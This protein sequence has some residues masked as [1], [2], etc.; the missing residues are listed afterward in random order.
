MWV[1]ESFIEELKT[2]K[3]QRNA[4]FI[5][6][7]VV[8]V[9]MFRSCS[10]DT[11][12]EKFKYEQNIAALRD[13]VRTYE[14]KNGDLVSEKTAL[15]TDKSELKKNVPIYGLSSYDCLDVSVLKNKMS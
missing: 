5:G 12:I 15:I 8:L 6:L 9:I 1:L 4:L 11:D 2:V 14:T 7:V 13:S 10:G 3:G